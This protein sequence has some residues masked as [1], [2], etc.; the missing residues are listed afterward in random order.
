MNA[1]DG[2]L[3]FRGWSDVWSRSRGAV[4]ETAWPSSRCFFVSLFSLGD[5]QPAVF[6][7]LPAHAVNQR[8]P[9][10]AYQHVS[11]T[12]KVTIVSPH[13]PPPLIPRPQPPRSRPTSAPFSEKKLS[14]RFPTSPSGNGRIRALCDKLLLV[15]DGLGNHGSGGGEPGFQR[16]LGDGG[17]GTGLNLKGGLLGLHLCDGPSVLGLNKLHLLKEVWKM[18]VEYGTRSSRRYCIDCTACA[19]FLGCR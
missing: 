18:I 14:F 19:V 15:S 13:A 16:M 8:L 5:R 3:L 4:S 6:V 12:G 7:V 17:A 2:R 9:S 11:N 1:V 10:H